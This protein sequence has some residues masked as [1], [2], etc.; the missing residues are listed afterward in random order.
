MERIKSLLGPVLIVISILVIGA[1]SYVGGWL[2]PVPDDGPA[3]VME[4]MNGYV[5]F[6]LLLLLVGLAAVIARR[7]AD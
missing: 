1:A 4:F 3:A 6:F 7:S 5:A 2:A